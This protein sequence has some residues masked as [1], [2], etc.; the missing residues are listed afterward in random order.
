[1][2]IKKTIFFFYITLFTLSPI[3][4]LSTPLSDRAIVEYITEYDMTNMINRCK[5]DFHYSD[6]DMITLERELK[7]FLILC[8]IE[9][10][11]DVE[12][13]MYSNDVDNLWHTF[14]LFTKEYAAFCNN[15]SERFIHHVPTI[16]SAPLT[17]EQKEKNITDFYAFVERY[18]TFFNEP[19]D[20]I[21]LLDQCS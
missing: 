15:V 2:N 17:T 8:T 6:D 21:W 5:K 19:I 3:T 20:N 12:M 14:I 9:K 10:N 11:K 7:R 1:M 18:E 16:N 4:A 13:G